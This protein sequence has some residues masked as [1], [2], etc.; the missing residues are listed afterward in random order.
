MNNVSATVNIKQNEWEIV[1]EWLWDNKEYFTALSFLPEDI[2]TYTQPP[3]ESITEEEYN[4]RIGHLHSLDLSKIV[5][6]DD[7]TALMDQ[8]AC[9]S[10]QCEI[11]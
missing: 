7:N 5:E 2:G 11:V 8:A 3:F 1:G 10:G 6:F 4:E 9:S